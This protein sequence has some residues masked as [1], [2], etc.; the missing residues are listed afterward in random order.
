MSSFE[1][2][3]AQVVQL[4]VLLGAALERIRQLEQEN[5]RLTQENARLRERLEQNST[6][7]SRPP[8]SD[9]PGTARAKRKKK[10]RGRRPGGQPGHPKHERALVPLQSGDQVVE[11]VPQQCQQCQRKLKGQDAEPQRHQVVEL[12]P[13]KARVTEYR[14]HQ[15]ECQWC[16]VD[17]SKDPTKNDGRVERVLAA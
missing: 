12:E 1:S 9:P 6:N 17:G 13:V 10:R 15:L 4:Q 16:G 3:P 5:E 8:S 11:L 7:S 14:C 2:I